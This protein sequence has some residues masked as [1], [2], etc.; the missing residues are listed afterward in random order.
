MEPLLETYLLGKEQKTPLL[1]KPKNWLKKDWGP[2]DVET[3]CV[4]LE[5]AGDAQLGLG[6]NSTALI[7][8]ETEGN[9][10][11]SSCA[12]GGTVHRK[13]GLSWQNYLLTNTSSSLTAP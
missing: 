12:T 7:K 4:E 11:R 9:G 5:P 6:A 10:R 3:A 2:S 1:V 8:E 13:K